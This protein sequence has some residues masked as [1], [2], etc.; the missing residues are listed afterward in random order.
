VVTLAS[1]SDTAVFAGDL[2]HSPVQ[3][4]HP[5]IDS[6]FCVDP[7]GARLSRR[8]LLQ[9]AADSRALVLPAHFRGSGAA[10]V[11]RHGDDFAI[12]GWAPVGDPAAA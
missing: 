4:A 9:Q 12:D 3:V 10:R 1:G 7:A 2:L 8:R 11:R 5:D 6:C